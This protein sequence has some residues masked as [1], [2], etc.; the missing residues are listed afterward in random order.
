MELDRTNTELSE[1]AA[2]VPETWL[3]VFYITSLI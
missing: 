2:T 3:V 1:T